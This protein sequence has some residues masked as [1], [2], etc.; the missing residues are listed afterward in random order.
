MP[1]AITILLSIKLVSPT[2]STKA[3]NTSASITLKS[4]MRPMPFAIDFDVER[5]KNMQNTSITP[6][7]SPNVLGIPRSELASSP[8]T[9]V[10]IPTVVIIAIK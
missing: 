4:L 10:P 1:I 7:L 5:V 9:G 3:K 6:S 2:I 8:S